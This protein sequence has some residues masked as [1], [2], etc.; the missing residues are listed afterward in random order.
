V[1]VPDP[2]DAAGEP[3]RVRRRAQ[4]LGIGA[5]RL[6][7]LAEPPGQGG[8]AVRHPNALGRRREGLQGVQDDSHVD[9]FLQQRPPHSRQ[10]PGRGGAHRRERQAHA[11][12]HRLQGD[13]SGAPRQ[14]RDLAEPA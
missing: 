11:R 12:D 14:H 4:F 5:D 2:V 8:V 3:E 9:A 13:P 7:I 1:R 10:Q 6:V